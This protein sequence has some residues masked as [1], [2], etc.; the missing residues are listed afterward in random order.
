[1]C[2]VS[3]RREERPKILPWQVMPLIDRS[4]DY[5]A[6]IVTACTNPTFRY[7]TA[8]FFQLCIM[9]DPVTLYFLALVSDQ[10]L[11]DKPRVTTA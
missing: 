7:V 11:G 1:M 8:L 2:P 10:N 6:P 3:S 5:T 9:E 4:V